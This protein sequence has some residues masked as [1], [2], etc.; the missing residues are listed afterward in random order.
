M[1]QPTQQDA[2]EF[3]QWLQAMRLESA[4]IERSPASTASSWADTDSDSDSDSERANHFATCSKRATAAAHK[5]LQPTFERTAPMLI[6]QKSR[7]RRAYFVNEF[8]E[9]GENSL[10]SHFQR[11]AT[12]S[13]SSSL[14]DHDDDDEE[15][16]D[17]D[18]PALYQNLAY[19][20]SQNARKASHRSS[21]VRSRS[22]SPSRS[23]SATSDEDIF[24]MEL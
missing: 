12:S 4:H 16:E 2:G 23:P 21:N 22:S 10:A 19:F 3:S 18:D 8:E 11:S 13:S 7:R 20:R 5:M 15:G 9:D 14:F 6:P 17:E 1:N 24:D